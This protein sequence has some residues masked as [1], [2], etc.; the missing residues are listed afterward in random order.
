MRTNADWENVAYMVI[1]ILI[2]VFVFDN[3]SN[4]LRSRL[5]EPAA[6]D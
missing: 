4:A 2:V 3:I 6:R 5:V 1:L